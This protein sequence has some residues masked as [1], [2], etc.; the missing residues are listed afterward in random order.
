MFQLMSSGKILPMGV[1]DTNSPE[2][3]YCSKNSNAAMNGAGCTAKA[4]TE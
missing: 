4:L 2:E 3:T 1:K